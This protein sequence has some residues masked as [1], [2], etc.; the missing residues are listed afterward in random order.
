MGV[1][2][3]EWYVERAN[4]TL[5]R[6]GEVEFDSDALVSN[7]NAAG[8]YVQAWVWVPDDEVPDDEDSDDTEEDE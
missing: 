6:D 4:D 8:A 5:Y 1:N 3:D 2:P 7:G